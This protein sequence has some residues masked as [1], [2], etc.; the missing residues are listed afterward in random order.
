MQL[1]IIIKWA[2][3]EEIHCWPA[4]SQGDHALWV[5]IGGFAGLACFACQMCENLQFVMNAI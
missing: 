2:K 4:V 5:L 1:N 3:F